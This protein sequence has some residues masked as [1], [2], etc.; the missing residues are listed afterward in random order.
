MVASPVAANQDQLRNCILALQLGEGLLTAAGLRSRAK[1]DLWEKSGV[2]A[3]GGILCFAGRNAG[4]GDFQNL[5]KIAAMALKIRDRSR[6]R[7]MDLY[8]EYFLN[9]GICCSIREIDAGVPY[10]RF[11]SFM[12]IMAN[13]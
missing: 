7:R 13:G 1:V 5:C 8:E 4:A 2:D 3:M 12:C 10:V 11:N 9:E 6:C